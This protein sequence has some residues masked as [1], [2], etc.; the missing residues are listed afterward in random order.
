MPL[1]PFL[2]A[3]GVNIKSEGCIAIIQAMI[4]NLTTEKPQLNLEIFESVFFLF[5]FFFFLFS[6]FKN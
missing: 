1:F 2:R 5:S 3:T 4:F 6:F